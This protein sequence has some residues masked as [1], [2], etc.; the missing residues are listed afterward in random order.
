[1]KIFYS[2]LSLLFS[3]PVLAM[4]GF[5]FSGNARVKINPHAN[6][7]INQAF[8]KLNGNSQVTVNSINDLSID[9]DGNST[10]SVPHPADKK[11]LDDLPIL[12]IINVSTVGGNDSLVRQLDQNTFRLNINL[13][14]NSTLSLPAT[15]QRAHIIGSGNAAITVKNDIKSLDVK[16]LRAGAYVKHSFF[17]SLFYKFKNSLLVAKLLAPMSRKKIETM[18]QQ[19]IQSQ[20][21][22]PAARPPVFDVSRYWRKQI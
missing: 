19:I 2:L 7:V 17:G 21:Q 11:N 1:M 8:I 13:S 16:R 20:R 3:L 4:E 14:G 18:S 6:Q 9:L 15:I 12:K 10:L 22:N 5:N